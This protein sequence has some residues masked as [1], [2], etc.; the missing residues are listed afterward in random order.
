MTLE[1]YPYVNGND[2]RAVRIGFLVEQPA[3][4]LEAAISHGATVIKALQDS[5]WRERAVISDPEGHIVELVS[6]PGFQP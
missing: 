6:S 3:K 5:P 4:C 1:I 2:T